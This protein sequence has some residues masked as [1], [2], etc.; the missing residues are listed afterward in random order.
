MADP[1][2]LPGLDAVVPAD[3][4]PLGDDTAPALLRL[5]G[6]RARQSESAR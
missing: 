5:P 4:E 2:S 6:E 3:Q 1:G